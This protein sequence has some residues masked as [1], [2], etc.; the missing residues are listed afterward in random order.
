MT[1]NSISLLPT[2]GVYYPGYKAR[3]GGGSFKVTYEAAEELTYEEYGR[4]KEVKPAEEVL[5]E[6]KKI[7]NQIDNTI[8]NR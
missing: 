3:K 6:A 4:R 2:G 7:I 5:I 8:P 1:Q